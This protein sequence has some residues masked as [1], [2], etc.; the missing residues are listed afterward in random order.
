MFRRGPIIARPSQRGLFDLHGAEEEGIAK[1][2]I[3]FP[4]HNVGQG[5]H[6]NSIR[7]GR[8]LIEKGPDG[9]II[10]TDRAMLVRGC[11]RSPVQFNQ[12][13]AAPRQQSHA[14]IMVSVR[15]NC[16]ALS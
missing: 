9:L 4:C 8:R 5:N 12:E 3:P 6:G 14:R 13:E 11:I 1:P 2:H 10:Q 7:I 16:N 15:L